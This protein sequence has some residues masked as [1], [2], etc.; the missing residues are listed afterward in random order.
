MEELNVKGLS[1][2][3]G[4]PVA[5]SI[6]E[7]FTESLKNP[8]DRL[9]LLDL[10]ITPELKREGLMR[11][12]IRQVQNARKQAG[13][14]VD[15]RIKLELVTHDSEL[16]KAID[17]HLDTIATE[18]LAS[19]LVTMGSATAEGYAIDVKVEDAALAIAFE[20]S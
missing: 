14:K 6:L 1:L 7:N 15:D 9:V 8:T 11:E 19:K 2:K 13:L 4:K 3:S 18:T 20:K 5:K 16:E 17:E 12:V 10:A